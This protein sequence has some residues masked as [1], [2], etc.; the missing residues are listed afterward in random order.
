[1]LKGMSEYSV[2]GACEWEGK[3]KR[4]TKFREAPDGVPLAVTGRGSQ[5]G[6]VPDGILGISRM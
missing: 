5:G 2:G 1:M 6:G 3:Q 4:G